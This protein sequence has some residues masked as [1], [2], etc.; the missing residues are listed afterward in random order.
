MTR[1]VEPDGTT[2]SERVRTRA[3]R[4]GRRRYVSRRAWGPI[5]FGPGMLLGSLG[6]LG[7]VISLFMPWQNG[8]VHPSGIPVEFLWD[9]TPGSNDPSLLILLVPFAIVLII[10]ALV[11]MGAGARLFG[12]IAV[13]IVV[14]VYAYQLN[15]SLNAFPGS[16]LGDVLDSGFYVA[17]VS[18]IIAFASGLL[19]SGWGARSEV[20]ES[21]VVDDR[22]SAA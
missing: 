7:V 2:R 10:G 4:A 21:D 19:P 5:A 8:G 11:P 17:A 14:G 1:T 3:E 15:R 12:A 20:V 18:G 16:D 22:G 6:A 9:R 13:L